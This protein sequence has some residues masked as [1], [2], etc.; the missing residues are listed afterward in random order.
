MNLS[1]DG[2]DLLILVSYLALVILFGLWMGRGKKDLAGYLLAGRDVIAQDLNSLVIAEGEFL[3]SEDIFETGSAN[4]EIG[5]ASAS[6]SS[7]SK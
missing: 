4:A 7:I 1:I 2:L 6:G 3:T 5:Q